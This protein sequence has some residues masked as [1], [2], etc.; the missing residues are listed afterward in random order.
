[1]MKFLNLQQVEA[2]MAGRF[3]VCEQVCGKGQ[4]LVNTGHSARSEIGSRIKSLMDKWKQLQELAATRRTKLE[5]GIEAH[6]VKVV[7]LCKK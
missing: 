5:D 3:P 6:Q 2:E 1:M 7:S 4:D